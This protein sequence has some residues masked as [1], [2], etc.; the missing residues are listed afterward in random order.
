MSDVQL[1][2]AERDVKN[3]V[4]RYCRGV[5]RMDLDLVRSCYHP[6]ADDHHGD[7]AGGVDEALGWVWDVLATYSSTVHLVAN[8]LV[9]IDPAAPGAAR[10]ESYGMAL[11]FDGGEGGRRGQAMGF[12]WIDDL[13]Q[14]P[15]ADGAHEWRFSRR[16]ATTEWIRR[17]ADDEFTPIPDRFLK[18]RRDRDDPVYQ[19]GGDQPSSATPNRS[20]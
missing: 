10:C 20:E 18:G 5:D 17:F 19:R 1:L 15:S 7:F 6:D 4:L 8:M 3:V 12:R 9:E 14:R 2:L 11:H 16:V 13:E